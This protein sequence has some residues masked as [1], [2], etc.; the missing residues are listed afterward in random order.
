MVLLGLKRGYWLAIAF[1]SADGKSFEPIGSFVGKVNEPVKLL[2]QRS[3][4]PA[5]QEEI[6][7]VPQEYNGTTMFLEAMEDSIQV[8]DRGGAKIG[9]IHIWSYAGD[10]YQE[11][12]EETLLFGELKNADALVLDLRDG[13][14]GAWPNYLNIFGEGLRVTSVRRDGDRRTTASTWDKPVVLLVNERSRSGKEILAYGFQTLKLGPVVGSKT[15]GAVVAGTAF[16]LED[17]SLLYLAVSDVYLDEG[18]RLEGVGVVPDIEVPFT[19]DYAQG[20][21]PQK[22]R[23]LVV[24]SQL[25]QQPAKTS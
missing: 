7:V 17:G 23:A 13:W 18:K 12:L 14:G 6:A 19:V 10:Q 4:A 21:D 1:L 8:M 16:I 15:A 24:A 20:A 2:I 9:Y 11:K 22:E 25:V 5:S 3:P